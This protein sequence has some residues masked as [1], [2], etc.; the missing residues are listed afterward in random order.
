TGGRFHTIVDNLRAAVRIRREL[1]A[2]LR[3]GFSLVVMRSNVD[4]LDAFVDLAASCGVDWIK[5]EEVA[6]VTPYAKLSLVRMDDAR[7]RDAV[8][9]CVARAQSRGLVAVDH[10]VPIDLWRCQLDARAARF[11][12]ADEFANR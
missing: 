2:D 3:L 1:G 7:V 4:E 9:A 6:P 11:L 12:A 5:L 8:R 10:T